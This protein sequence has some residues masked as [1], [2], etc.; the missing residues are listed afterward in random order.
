MDAL[1]GVSSVSRVDSWRSICVFCDVSMLYIRSLMAASFANSPFTA[2]IEG[3]LIYEVSGYCLLSTI[4][5]LNVEPLV[6][7]SAEMLRP[8]TA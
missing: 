7:V 1:A 8:V 4:V 2:L 5:C 3:S 6:D